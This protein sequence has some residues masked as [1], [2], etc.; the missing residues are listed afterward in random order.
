M[1][2]IEGANALLAVDDTVLT[3]QYMRQ[4][5]TGEAEVWKV[6]G[7]K[8]KRTMRGY[9]KEYEVVFDHDNEQSYEILKDELVEL[10]S[11]SIIYDS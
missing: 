1:I 6:I 3:F 4:N 11:E 8:E 7:I 2:D 9:K 10:L 5:A